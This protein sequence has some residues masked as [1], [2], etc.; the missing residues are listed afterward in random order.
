MTRRLRLLRYLRPHKWLLVVVLATIGFGVLVDVARPWPTALLV[1]NVLGDK[2]AGGVLEALPGPATPEGLLPWVAIGTIL[3]FVVGMAMR[4]VNEY[5]SVTLAQRMEFELGAD[6]FLH[7]QRLSVLFHHR[8]PLGDTI[9]RVTGDSSCVSV[10]VTGA[11]VPLIQAVVL[12][13]VMFVIMLQLQTTLTLLALAVIPFLILSIRLLAAPMLMRNREARDLEGGMMNVVERTLNSVPVVQ[14]FTRENYEHERYRT[15]GRELVRA[16]QRSTTVGMTFQLLTGLVTAIGTAGITYIGAKYALEGKLTAGDIIV[17]LSYLASLYGPINS[18]TSTNETIQYAAAQA[19]R[20]LDLMEME[21]GVKDSPDAEEIQVAGSVRFDDVTFGYQE[22][23]PVLKHVSFD[24]DPGDVVAIVGPTGAGKTTLVNMLV[25]FFDPW[26]GTVTLDGHNLRDVKLRSLREQTAMVLQDPYIFPFTAAENIAYGKPDASREEVVAAAKA[27]NAH[28]FIMR[29]PEGYDTVIGERGGTLS[30]G[31]KQRLSIA[32]AFLKDA[33]LLILDEPTSALD[34]RTERMLLDALERLMEGRLTFIIAHRLSTIRHADKILVVEEGE[35]VEQGT[36]AELVAQGGLYSRLYHQQMEIATHE[37]VEPDVDTLV[38]VDEGEL[39]EA[40]ALKRE[41]SER[42][43]VSVVIDNYNY[44]RFLGQAIESAQAQR[45]EPIE[46]IVV[47][48]GSTDDSRDV[49]SRY[50]GVVAVLKANGGQ[51]SAINAGF[52]V[53]RGDWVCFLDAD[54]VLLPDAIES[55][56][57]GAEPG[58]AKVQWPMEESDES[59]ART[60]RTWPSHPLDSGE[61]SD[62]VLLDGPEGYGWAWS[63]GGLFSRSCLEQVLPLDEQEGPSG[64]GVAYVDATLASLAPLYGRIATI[65]RPLSLHRIHGANMSRSFEFDEKLAGDIWHYDYR[66]DLLARHAERL[67]HEVDP[68]DWRR[69]SWLHRF[70]DA[71]TRIHEHVPRGER[72]VLIDE[73]QVGDE[74]APDREV[75]PFTE[76]HGVY[77]G[78]PAD[79]QQAIEEIDRLIGDGAWVVVAWPAFWWLDHY[80]GLDA[81]LRSVSSEVIAE[82][83]IVVFRADRKR[84]GVAA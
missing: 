49:L 14:A 63:C 33:P 56:L 24:A 34:A 82:D 65:D 23:R 17:F 16:Y 84:A 52:D 80:S 12:T 7:L 6:L 30:G 37:G 3:I 74:V 19:D 75:I 13:I 61:L 59:G 48:D 70:A 81:H 2:P 10:M 20:V 68:E 38:R 76:R 54:D 36:H 15:V 21:P 62:A 67:G 32:R 73:G 66:C 78:P 72:I 44:G 28:D 41:T 55:A 45:Y 29:L 79:D 83:G 57:A 11:L 64:R 71:R 39:S 77:W 1:D 8:R 43:L 31:E 53:A 22:G 51:P 4:V 46:V 60:G 47:D 42:P 25:R 35:I 5:A 18:I 58:V 50:D 27:A 9:A 26:S 69:R 40:D